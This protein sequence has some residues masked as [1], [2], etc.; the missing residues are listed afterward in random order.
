[1]A[2][3]DR[4]IERYSRQIILPEIGGRGQERLLASVM[5]VAGSGALMATTARYLAGA[6]VGE[7]RLASAESDRLGGEL[8]ALDP[9]LAVHPGRIDATTTVVVAADL[10]VGPLDACVRRA[11]EARVPVV[12]AAA[13]GAAG[14]LYVG[15][16]ASSCAGCAARSARGD[17]IGAAASPLAPIAAGVLGSLLALAALELA[18]GRSRTAPPLR[19]FDARSAALTPLPLV[20][21]ADCG[22]CAQRP[23]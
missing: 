17:D 16:D 22:G 1:M 9:D 15:D 20:R 8:R 13:R 18:L 7:L 23:E 5:V 6:G 21:A 4:Q 14:W 2:L 10:G 3:S 19:W 11:R 12:A